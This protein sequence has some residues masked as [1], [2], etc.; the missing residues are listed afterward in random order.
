MVVSKHGH[1]IVERNK[2]KRRL[3]ELG[4]TLILPKLWEAGLPMDV[5]LRARREAYDARFSELEAELIGVTEETC[6]RL[7]SSE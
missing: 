6:S 1:D 4:R 5:L 7:R 2:L 3:K